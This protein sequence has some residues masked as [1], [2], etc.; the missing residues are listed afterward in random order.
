MRD[1]LF[2][3]HTEELPPKSLKKLSESL[4]HEITTRLTNAKFTFVKSQIFAT[5][6]RLGVFIHHLSE[7]QPNTTIEKRGP[8]LVAAFQNGIP[9]KACEGFARS[10][11][12]TPKELTT[13]KTP[14]GEWVGF[15]QQMKGKTVV[16]LLPD[17]IR[18]ALNALPIPKRMRWSDGNIA[19]IRPVHS[20]ILLYGN[21]VVPAEILGM[22]TGRK[23]EGHRFL[24]K[25]WVNI[26]TPALYEKT[27]E[28]KFV[29]VSFEKR[30][31][32]IMLAAKKLGQKK[33]EVILP[34]A[35]LDEVTGLVEWP[36][37]L[38]GTFDEKFLNV[39]PE[40]LIAAMQDHQRYF[41]CVDKKGKLLPYFIFIS[42]IKSKKPQQVIQG[43][44][45]VLRARLSDAAFFFETD[46]HIKLIDRTLLLKN[47]L[48]Q[49]KLGT[50]HDK[51]ERVA[52][53]SF[54]IA[55]MMSESGIKTK[56]AAL[57]AKADLT[58]QLVQEF[59]ELQG[60]AGC[61]YAL[62]EG[63]PTETAVALKEHY[64]PRFSGDVLPESPMG[65]ILAIA[66]RLDTLV[67]IFGIN[68]IPT[69]D[70][71]PF[72]LRRNA[73]GILRIL[74]E[75][76]LNL[77]L[78]QLILLAETHYQQK[79][80]NKNVAKD[81]MQF[82]LDRLK[83]RYQDQNVSPQIFTSV[84]AL[85]V[86]HPLDIQKRIQA[87]IAFKQLP[88]ADALSEANKRV[89]NIL[90]KYKENIAA[91]D[92]NPALFQDDAERNLFENLKMASE[93]VQALSK[94]S[95]YTNILKNL[96]ALRT[97]IDVFF[98]KV[99][100]MADDKAQRENRLLLLKKLRELFLHV[101]DVAL[102]Q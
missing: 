98:E 3:I 81:V 102:L 75:K 63:L 25:G 100:V 41:P 9:T 67:G 18:D 35:L 28:K 43:N 16:S 31:N 1:F 56:R 97:S 76:E 74:I 99:L 91:I 60:I 29:I 59:P 26:T 8:A 23:T 68:L 50:L 93:K 44:E 12:I 49:N 73:I 45:R 79:L 84:A 27:L 33:G 5:P 92:I 2:E 101:A 80:E 34:D 22:K 53:L 66:D 11:N 6:R 61:Y 48:F 89:S 94:N 51:A 46:K 83:Q 77:D 47:I 88:D 10:L 54:Q 42:N 87:V 7:K 40:A 78:Y 55:N 72:G 64:L 39:P 32:K 14:D 65:A 71:D 82:M 62:S 90:S 19:F 37:A 17:I 58:T 20:V 69:G 38:M 4:H 30:K 70:K 13:I 85:N 57:L 95:D 96:A 36:E 21:K 52:E 15:Q 86:T 24:S